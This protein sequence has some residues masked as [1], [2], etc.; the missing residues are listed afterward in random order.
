MVPMS[1]LIRDKLSWWTKPYNLTEGVVFP[2]PPPTHVITTDASKW[3]WGGHMGEL[4]FAGRW[5]TVE[6]SSHINL[7]ELWAVVRTFH[8]LQELITGKKVLV[9]SDN[10]TVV[11]YLNKQGGTRSPTLCL[12]TLQFL[13]WCQQRRISVQAS[14]IAG[15]ENIL[16]DDLSRGRLGSPT[17]W[18]LNPQVVQRLF[19]KVFHPS[20]DLFAA[21]SNHQ[22]PVYCARLRDHQA[23]AVDALSISWGGVTAYAFPPISLLARVVSKIADEDC[24]VLLIAPFW[25]RQLWFRPLVD[26]L[27][28]VP[29]LLPPSPDLLRM[30]GSRGMVNRDVAHLQLTAW[31]L[32]GNVARRTAFL[33]GLRN[34]SPVDGERLRSGLILHVWLPTGT[35]VGSKV[36][37][38]PERL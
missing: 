34:S 17:E 7:L 13:E 36:A 33:S 1:E 4:R 35:G 8:A 26:L 25:P 31:P 18:T 11:A 38:L 32:S 2:A 23:Y 24:N 28:G 6:A 14:H 3:G 20:I 29:Q 37:L 30:P 27:M 21:A 10:S 12:H 16:A 19:Q 22:L 9:Q 15:V 5:S